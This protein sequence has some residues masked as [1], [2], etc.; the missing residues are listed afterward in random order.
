MNYKIGSFTAFTI[1][2]FL[3]ALLLTSCSDKNGEITSQHGSHFVDD[4][5]VAIITIRKFDDDQMQT[6]LTYL[7]LPTLQ[8]STYRILNTRSINSAV[9][10][11]TAY[12]PP[13]LA[14]CAYR[15]DYNAS[16]KIQVINVETGDSQ[17]IT[18]LRP[19]Y[20]SSSGKY[21]LYSGEN[22][23]KRVYNFD[24]DSS[25]KLESFE[26]LY[27]SDS[28]QYIVGLRGEYLCRYD[29]TDRSVD[30]L[31]VFSSVDEGSPRRMANGLIFYTGTRYRQYVIEPEH[32]EL[33]T[34]SEAQSLP[35]LWGNENFGYEINLNTS[36]CIQL[37]YEIVRI[38]D[39]EK[40]ELIYTRE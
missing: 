35:Q 16:F 18:G 19:S 32:Y 26:P 20:I 2:S 33:G 37:G 4:S 6:E 3:L 38:Y 10:P 34:F 15:T 21:L 9:L 30:T 5:T 23:E 22:W 1:G 31:R 27:V 12:S 11:T 25:H 7:S 39:Y 24:T 13:Y 28:D 17:L 14:V 8:S 40:C 29:L 36:H